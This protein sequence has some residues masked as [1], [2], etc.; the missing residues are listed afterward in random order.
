MTPNRY[1]PLLRPGWTYVE[2]VSLEG[3][4]ASDWARLNV[5]R[6]E[7]Y[8]VE[9]ARQALRMLKRQEHDASFGY[10]VNN[11]RHCLQSAT[12]AL[13]AGEDEETVAVSLLHDIGFVVCP[14]MHPQFAAA[15][16]GA[17]VSDR[18]YWMLR[19]HAVFQQIHIHDYPGLDPNERER[20]R[21]HPHFEW[22]AR[23]VDRYDQ[24]ATDPNYGCEPLE[25]FVPMVERLFARPPRAR[26]PE[27][28]R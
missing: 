4:D 12:M 16:L 25:V 23:W 14:D 2:K 19:Y 15:L 21:G 1:S 26:G 28:A 17:Y 13:R 10:M 27:E 8:G 22:T 20:W 11:Y 5:Q 18:N 24:A 6:A 3:F 7:Y 9:Q